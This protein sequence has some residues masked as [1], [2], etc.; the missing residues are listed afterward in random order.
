M[1]ILIVMILIVT[2]KKISFRKWYFFLHPL[3]WPSLNKWLV[4]LIHLGYYAIYWVKFMTIVNIFINQIVLFLL[5]S[6]IGQLTKRLLWLGI[7][8]IIEV[9]CINRCSILLKFHTI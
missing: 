2:E 6:F 8:K 3:I 5:E 1:I 9:G 4:Y 7:I